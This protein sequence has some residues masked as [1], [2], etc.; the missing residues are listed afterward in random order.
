MLSVED[1]WTILML[2]VEDKKRRLGQA[3]GWLPSDILSRKGSFRISRDVVM[4]PNRTLFNFM[5]NFLVTRA[6]YLLPEDCLE[7]FALSPIFKPVDVGSVIP[8]YDFEISVLDTGNL[9]V[10]AIEIGI[11]EANSKDKILKSLDSD[12]LLRKIDSGTL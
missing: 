5:S 10:K 1:K 4:K 12:R 9:Y 8:Y 11:N 3:L 2:S 7:Y 6:E